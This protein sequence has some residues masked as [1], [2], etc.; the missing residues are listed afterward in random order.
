M[1]T[2]GDLTEV[3]HASVP[4]AAV[5]TA[6]VVINGTTAVTVKT[7]L[8]KV[9]IVILTFAEAPGTPTSAEPYWTASGETVTIT[10]SIGSGTVKMSMLALGLR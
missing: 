6:N 9:W 10:D 3:V 4:G 5:Y 2:A 7:G 8:S 1:A